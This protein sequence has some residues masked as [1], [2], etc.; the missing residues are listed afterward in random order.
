[1]DEVHEFEILQSQVEDRFQ[2]YNFHTLHM[3]T[4]TKL[5]QY[6]T[7]RTYFSLRISHQ[8]ITMTSVLTL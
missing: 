6:S 1:M 7:A 3:S 8:L 5:R 2:V 4:S